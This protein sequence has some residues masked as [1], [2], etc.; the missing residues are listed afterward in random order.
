M[1][2]SRLSLLLAG[3]LAVA[4]AQAQTAAATSSVPVKSGDD[5]TQVQ[6]QPNMDPNSPSASRMQAD[7][8][9]PSAPSYP[10]ASQSGTSYPAATTTPGVQTYPSAQVMPRTREEVRQ[11]TR[12]MGAAAATTSVPDRAG[13]ASTMVRGQPNVDP[14]AP[15]LA[16]PVY[17]HR[18]GVPVTLP[19]GSPSV[20]QGGTPQ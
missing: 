16:P 3:L 2:K 13:E 9:A 7:P 15:M 4:G 11:E 1:N 20:F 12:G 6:G 19:E 8:G 5:S 10:S 18:V 14:N 17:N